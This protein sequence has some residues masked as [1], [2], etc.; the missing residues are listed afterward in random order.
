MVRTEWREAV[1]A[2][3][4]VHDR[5]QEWKDANPDFERTHPELVKLEE[6]RRAVSKR[7]RFGSTKHDNNG[8]SLGTTS[9]DESLASPFGRP[10][11]E[12]SEAQ[13]AA[14]SL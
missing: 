12:A 3:S 2:L 11:M 6:E 7:I 10:S 14:L 4:G 5:I 13:D 9:I 8:S 1:E